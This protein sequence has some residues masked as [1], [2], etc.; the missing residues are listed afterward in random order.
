MRATP[1][2]AAGGPRSARPAAARD[3]LASGESER[4]FALARRSL[5]DEPA[6][7]ARADVLALLGDLEAQAGELEA[8]AA[9]RRE[10][11]LASPTATL[12]CQSR[13]HEQL[14]YVVRITESLDVAVAHA[15][16]ALRLAEQVADDP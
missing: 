14:A 5:A 13:L 11:L 10:A 15:R 2:E 1:A 9:H 3:H 16:E 7:R 4:G 12:P 6:G 8:A